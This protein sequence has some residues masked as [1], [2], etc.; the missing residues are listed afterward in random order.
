MTQVWING[1]IDNQLDP[2]DRGLSY[3]DG[4]FATMRVADGCPLFL[5]QH[6]KRLSQGAKRLGFH[7]E[8]QP[9]LIEQ[10]M[11]VAKPHAQAC[12]KLLITRGAGGRGYAP[13]SAVT[14]TEVLS[15]H[16]IPL[17]YSSWQQQGIALKTS[18]VL[19]SSQP[20][21]AGVKHLNRL[22]QVLIKSQHLDGDY[23]DWLVLD[24]NSRVIESSMAN[25]FCVKGNQVVTP[26][27]SHSG[28]SGVMREQVI[29]ELIELGLDINVGDL[30]YKQLA[31]FDQI[32]ITNSLLGV[33]DINRIDDISFSKADFSDRIREKYQLT[34]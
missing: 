4:L 7:W 23:D 9:S 21:L 19:L 33:V 27:I 8:P 34:L 22:E 3:G 12:L 5:S 16:A 20:R 28:V 6:L 15:V 17:H 31:T 14:V 24:A 10:I 11:Q 26:A 18:P 2:F 30:A 29:Y 1:E 32:F 13:P 25:I